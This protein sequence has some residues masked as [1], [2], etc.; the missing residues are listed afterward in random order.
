[1]CR[2]PGHGDKKRDDVPTPMTE[3]E[4]EQGWVEVD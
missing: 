2:R 1:M 4:A 3:N